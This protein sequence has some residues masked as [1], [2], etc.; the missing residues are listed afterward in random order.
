M[1]EVSVYGEVLLY[2]IIHCLLKAVELFILTGN[3][4]GGESIYGGTFNGEINRHNLY[5]HYHHHHNYLLLL[6]P[7]KSQSC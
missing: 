5:Q 1:I 6:R 7:C 2:M 3:G 4:T